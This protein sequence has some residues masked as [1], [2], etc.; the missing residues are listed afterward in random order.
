MLNVMID[1]IQMKRFFLLIPLVY[2]HYLVR[3]LTVSIGDSTEGTLPQ[4]TVEFTASVSPEDTAGVFLPNSYQRLIA[5]QDIWKHFLITFTYIIV[6][7]HKSQYELLCRNCIFFVILTS[8]NFLQI[9]ANR[10]YIFYILFFSV[11]L[12][13]IIYQVPTWLVYEYNYFSLQQWM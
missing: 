5:W 11:W 3:T 8:F 2:S 4:N 10:N 13:D 1:E 9:N 6:V 7:L 12:F